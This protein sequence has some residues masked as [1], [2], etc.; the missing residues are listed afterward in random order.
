MR[1]I[2]GTGIPTD[3]YKDYWILLYCAF[4]NKLLAFA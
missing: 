2:R 3:P 1:L 4:P